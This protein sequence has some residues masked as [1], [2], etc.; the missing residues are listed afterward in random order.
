[1]QLYCRT[2]IPTTNMKRQHLWSSA[3][4]IILCPQFRSGLAV[5]YKDNYSP[6]GSDPTELRVKCRRTE[7]H[8]GKIFWEILGRRSRKD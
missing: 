4:T 7:W 2:Q 5:T 3:P 8:L 1:M 6:W